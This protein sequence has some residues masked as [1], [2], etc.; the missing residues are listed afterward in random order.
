MLHAILHIHPINSENIS[1]VEMYDVAV[2]PWWTH[3]APLLYA[4]F[5]AL[6]CAS[7]PNS[8]L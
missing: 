2:V 5:N 3:A 7:Q 8:P 1:E 4:I 6:R